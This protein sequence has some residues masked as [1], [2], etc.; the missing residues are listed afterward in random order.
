MISTQWP[1]FLLQTVLFLQFFTS[2]ASASS[3]LKRVS[4]RSISDQDDL[5]FLDRD[6]TDQELFGSAATPGFGLKT[7]AYLSYEQLTSLIHQLQEQ[8][9]NLVRV[10]SIGKSV[11]GRDLWAVEITH[12]VQ[13]ERELLKPMFKYV[14]NMHGDETVGQALM[15]FLIQYLVY[16]DQVDDRVTNLLNSTDVYILPTVNPDGFSK[17]KEGVCGSLDGYVGRKNAA[18]VD[19]NRNFPDQF[20]NNDDNVYEPETLAIMNYIRTQP[21]VLSGNLHGGAIVASYPYDSSPYEENCCF[22]S[23]VPDREFFVQLAR[24]YANRNPMMTKPNACG[25]KFDG[26]IT[27]GN[28]WYKVTGG[29]QDFNYVHSNC[30]EITMELSC[31]KYPPGHQLPAYWA[32]NKESLLNFIESTRKGVYGLVV[33]KKGRPIP[34]ARITVQGIKKDISVTSR[35]EYWRLLTPGQYRIRATATGYEPG[36]LKSINVD[37]KEPGRLDFVLV[38]NTKRR[39]PGRSR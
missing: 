26:G 10:G 15:V 30:F 39:G 29:M 21:F 8:Y 19:L 27:N 36:T 1:L 18:G 32:A 22:E 6:Q 25:F 37:D 3:S 34:T 28:N 31:C 11:E 14:A 4:T 9:P 23:K 17:S 13:D 38:K 20:E 12:D 24:N 35:G 2:S 33:D 7:D 5:T 16:N